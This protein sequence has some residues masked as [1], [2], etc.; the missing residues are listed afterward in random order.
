[1]SGKPWRE[2]KIAIVTPWYGPDI[3]GGAEAEA[4]EVATHLQAA[5]YA[6][7]VLT[8]CIRDFFAPWDKNHHQPGLEMVQGVPVR[9][10]AVI[11]RDKAA[12]DAIN[13]QLMLGKRITP[14]EEEIF[15]HEMFR[16]PELLQFIKI[17]GHEYLFFFIP[18]MFPTT[19]WGSQVYPRR[20]AIIPC[21]HDEAYAYL[22]LFQQVLPKV[23]TL[24]FNV[25]SELALAE[26]IFGPGNGQQRQVIGL[27]VDTAFTFDAARFRQRYGVEYPFLLYVGRRDAGKNVPLLLDYWQQYVQERGT[28]MRLLLAGAGAVAIAPSLA[29]H[30]VDLG[31]LGAQDKYDAFA[32]ADIFCMPSVN[33]SF[34]I[35]T[36]EAWLTETPVLVHGRCPVTRDHVVHS[37]GGL[38][39]TNYA[40]FAATLDY[41]QAHPQ[42]GRQMGR[43]GRAYVLQHYQWPNIIAKYSQ[44]ISRMRKE[45]EAQQF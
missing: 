36:M 21:L 24:V 19:Y 40:E 20:S 16:S 13:Q 9:R 12:F 38:Y 29:A 7:E 41:F 26:R 18:Y 30:V 32:A 2:M 34:S 45:V 22:P 44:I 3:P 23:N 31:F 37:N 6:V 43:N 27:G 8:T 5:G 25:P 14:A 17:H 10:F 39:F 1:M 4:R 35:V 15:A 33:E 11:K 42:Q 28:E